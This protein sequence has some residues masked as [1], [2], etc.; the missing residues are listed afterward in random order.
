[1]AYPHVI[2]LRGPWECVQVVAQTPL[3]DGKLTESSV[4][5][6]ENVRI[7]PPADWADTLGANFR[8]RVGYSRRFNRPTNLEPHERVWLVVEG[9]DARG[10]VA[11]DGYA[12]GTIDGYALPAEWDITEFLQPSSVIHIDVELPPTG[13]GHPLPTRPG[14]ESLAGG[15]IG[16]VRLEIRQQYYVAE[17]STYWTS[18][19]VPQLHVAGRV[20]GPS[21]HENLKLV[22]TACNRELAYQSVDS[23]APFNLV[24]TIDDWPAWPDPM[25]EPVL[26]PV[27]IRLTNGRTTI[28]QT[29]L[30]TAPPQPDTERTRAAMSRFL[31]GDNPLAWLD[32][33]DITSGAFLHALAQPGRVIGLRGIL[34]DVAYH[35]LDRANVGVVQ[36]IPGAWTARVCPRLAHH[37]CILAWT[38][39][40]EEQGGADQLSALQSMFHRRWLPNITM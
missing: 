3:A 34:P 8:V 15:L 18:G 36:Q 4:I 1:M 16:E 19:A 5:L 7:K 30:E 20:A 26:T 35:K 22:V 29:T 11:L 13:V 31:S 9:V 27:E 10:R 37:P 38:L 21:S 17:L 24:A 40:A 23:G 28:W 2:R 25:D 32:Y 6:P 33:V 12:L 39:P 14:R